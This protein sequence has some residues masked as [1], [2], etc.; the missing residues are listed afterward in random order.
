MTTGKAIGISTAAGL[1]LI[2][3]GWFAT[4]RKSTAT[5][6]QTQAAA[7]APPNA[8]HEKATLEEQLK[9]NPGHTPV[10]LRLAQLA[11]EQSQPA[12]ARKHLDAILKAEPANT[13][14]L[15]ELGR[16]CYELNDVDCATKATEKIL[17]VDPGH[18]DALYNLGAIYANLGQNQ[19]ARQYWERAAQ[20]ADSSESGKKAAAALK[21]LGS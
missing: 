19:R 16:A 9:K 13:E 12:E 7:P 17:A 14:A 21:Q 2:A 15:L 10:L 3:T 11:T 4:H 20:K 18:A 1:L 6:P 5:P 8:A